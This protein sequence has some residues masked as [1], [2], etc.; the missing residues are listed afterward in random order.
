MQIYLISFPVRGVKICRGELTWLKS[1]RGFPIIVMSYNSSKEKPASEGPTLS[2]AGGRC[3]VTGRSVDI[4]IQNRK[5]ST[6]T[7]AQLI[8]DS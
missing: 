1:S 3:E 4:T 6:V 7:L 8:N 5:S 2:F